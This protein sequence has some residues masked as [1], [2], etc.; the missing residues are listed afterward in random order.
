MPAAISLA[1]A[2]TDSVHPSPL[3]RAPFSMG[4][5]WLW[6]IRRG[7]QT[8]A[9]SLHLLLDA[10]LGKEELEAGEGQRN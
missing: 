1:Q 5:E 3:P 6:L 2:V 7:V 8:P 10:C 4:N 9:I